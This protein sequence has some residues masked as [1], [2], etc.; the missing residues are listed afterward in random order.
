MADP[1]RVHDGATN[2]ACI[3]RLYESFRRQ[4]GAAM[5]DCYHPHAT[6][7]DPVFTNLRGP[8]V[9][10]MWAMLC[11]RAKD[12][13]LAYSSVWADGERGGA[14]WEADYTFASTG[15]RVHNVI[16]AEFEFR[17]GLI[18][19]H[20]DRFS[21]WRWSAMALGPVGALFGWSP[22]VRSSIRRKAAAGLRQYLER[23]GEAHHGARPGHDGGEAM[24]R[25]GDGGGGP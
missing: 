18:L 22:P 14:H 23:K 7:S 15:R 8:E 10:A 19:R 25:D 5:A 13:E 9:G 21:L 17:E 24:G 1:T 6:F 11:G 20:A 12:F 16:E 4:D 3:L 2:G